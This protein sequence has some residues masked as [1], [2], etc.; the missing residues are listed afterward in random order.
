VQL[1]VGDSD[2][3]DIR[4]NLDPMFERHQ[5]SCPDQG[6]SDQIDSSNGVSEAVKISD[7]M[8]IDEGES[9]VHHGLDHEKSESIIHES[10]RE[11]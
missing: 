8:H 4:I 1:A 7:E 2:G 6:N 5:G 9:L 3:F 11:A 10:E